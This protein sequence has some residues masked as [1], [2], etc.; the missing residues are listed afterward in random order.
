MSQKQRLVAIALLLAYLVGNP[1]KPTR[2]GGAWKVSL[3][4]ALAGELR[5]AIRQIG[6]D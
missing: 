2:I 5:E 1:L 4:G 3:T 6:R